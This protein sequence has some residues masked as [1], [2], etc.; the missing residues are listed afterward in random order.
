MQV[1]LAGSHHFRGAGTDRSQRP[2]LAV[3]AGR[4]PDRDITAIREQTR[5]EDIVG[6]Y[7]QLTRAGADS[8]TA[9]VVRRTV[10]ETTND[11]AA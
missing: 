4:I 8:L 10:S 1:G 5:I 7:V 11:T 3:V 2:R 9:R 6:D